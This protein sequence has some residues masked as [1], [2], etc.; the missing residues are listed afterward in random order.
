ML[1]ICQSYE[2]GRDA[3]L[4]GRSMRLRVKPSTAW[5]WRVFLLPVILWTR[6]FPR[7]AKAPREV[8]PDAMESDG[9]TQDA[10][11]ARL[12]RVSAEAAIALRHAAGQRPAPSMT[13]AYF[14]PLAPLT[15]MRLLNAHTRHHTQSLGRLAGEIAPA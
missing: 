6:R 3:V 5:L 7:G 12:T 13:H 8:V 10:A 1:H 15:T 14:G 4:E 9:L 11:V 2:I